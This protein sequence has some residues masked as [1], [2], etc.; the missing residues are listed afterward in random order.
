MISARNVTFDNI[1]AIAAA[2]FAVARDATTG[3]RV[4]IIPNLPP[5][6]RLRCENLIAA[7]DRRQIFQR[8]FPD[9]LDVVI[10]TVSKRILEGTTTFE[11]FFPDEYHVNGGGII[12]S[13][14]RTEQADGLARALPFLLEL[15]ELV[16]AVHDLMHAERALGE[17]R[18]RL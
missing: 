10:E 16:L 1:D 9:A 15:Q 11:Q 8:N 13:Q 4:D 7:I 18:E 6:E 5:R 14:E 3:L 17:L 12:R 2:A